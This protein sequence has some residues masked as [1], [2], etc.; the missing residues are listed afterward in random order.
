MSTEAPNDPWPGRLTGAGREQ[1]VADLRG[2]LLRGLAH[3]LAG[4]QGVDDAF[5]EDVTQDAVIKIL[6]AL[7]TFQGR[8]L[9]REER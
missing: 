7:D 2:L 1:A 4:R 5:L 9:G 3:A 8:H 6:A